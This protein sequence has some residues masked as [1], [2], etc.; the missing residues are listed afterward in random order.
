MTEQLGLDSVETLAPDAPA[1]PLGKGSGL[2]KHVLLDLQ[3]QE[4]AIA[5]KYYEIGQTI[6]WK[7][8]AATLIGFAV[9]VSLFPLTM[10]DVVPL[11]AAFVVS[12]LIATAGLVTEHE[13]MHSTI[14]R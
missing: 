1:F 9:W 7:Y 8:V 3:R 11:W 14:G 5:K 4:R 10:L 12:Y 6:R 2:D 13:A